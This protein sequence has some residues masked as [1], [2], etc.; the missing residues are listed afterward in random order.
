MQLRSPQETADRVAGEVP[1]GPRL[2][3]RDDPAK[4]FHQEDQAPALAERIA[5]LAKS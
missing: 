1:V 2:A 5:R 3:I 4:H